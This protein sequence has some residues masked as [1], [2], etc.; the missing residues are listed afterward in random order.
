MAGTAGRFQLKSAR[1]SAS[2]L[3]Q[4]AQTKRGSMSDSL[5]SSGQRSA[6]IAI[7]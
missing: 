4:A 3:P 6:L 7:E 5:K 1:T 2:R